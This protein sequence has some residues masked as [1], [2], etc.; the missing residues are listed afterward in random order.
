MQFIS[1]QYVASLTGFFPRSLS[2]TWLV[3]AGLLLASCD[4]TPSVIDIC[5]AGVSTITRTV[6]ITGVE[7]DNG[8]DAELV[9]KKVVRL[10]IAAR[11]N[12][13]LRSV[14]MTHW[15]AGHNAG[16]QTVEETFNQNMAPNGSR[17]VT[18]QVP[19][20]ETLGT[21]EGHYY[22]WTVTYRKADGQN[23][24]FIGQPKLIMPTKS[25]TAGTIVQAL[26]AAPP[27]PSV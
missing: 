11:Q 8:G 6:T 23:G 12:L 17:L 18:K 5:D 13:E 22:M 3:G 16:S 19:N 24:L 21:C 27:G 4:T 2:R 1:Q 20:T 15:D 10:N 26:C 14:L 25:I 9:G 7:I